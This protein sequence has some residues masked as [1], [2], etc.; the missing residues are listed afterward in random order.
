MFRELPKPPETQTAAEAMEVIRAWIVD[1]AL[2]VSLMPTAFEEK[3]VWGILLADVTNHVANALADAT[4]LDRGKT[5]AA[6]AKL[7][8]SELAQPTD[9]P[10]GEFIED[11]D[12]S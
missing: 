10:T 3:E 12:R 7:Y 1:G 4:G 8:N 2:H 9:E 5:V 6:I 11:E